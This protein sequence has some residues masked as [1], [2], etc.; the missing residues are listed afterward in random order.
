MG[1]IDHYSMRK[2]YNTNMIYIYIHPIIGILKV[3]K[4]K[5]VNY[6]DDILLTFQSFHHPKMGLLSLIYIPFGHLT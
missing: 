1:N 2:L 3:S 6:Y 4:E 5:L